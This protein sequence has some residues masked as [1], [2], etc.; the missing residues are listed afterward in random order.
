[1]AKKPSGD[2]ARQRA[3]ALL[4]WRR[5]RDPLKWFVPSPT[6]EAFLRRDTSV[7]PM[8]LVT[9]VSRGGKSAIT[10]ADFSMLMRGIHPHIPA[11]PNLHVTVFAPTRN[12]VANVLGRKLFEDSELK[13]P[14]DAPPEARNQPM[15]PAWEI[16]E[17]HRPLVDGMRVPKRLVMKNGNIATF[18]WTGVENQDTKIAGFRLDAAYVDE[19]AGNERLFSE[20]MARLTDALSDP[21]RKGLG[22]FVWAYTNTRHNE[23]YESFKR[24]VEEGRKGHTIFTILPGENPAITSEARELVGGA[25]SAEQRAIRMEGGHDAGELV[26]VF[27]RQ[28]NDARHIMTEE[29]QIG[30]DDNIWASYDPGVLHPMGMLVAALNRENPMTL[31]IVKT[32][33]LRGG[34]VE[35]DC[36][37]LVNFLRGRRLAGFVYDSNFNNRDRGGGPT[38]LQRF[39]ELM[40]DRGVVPLV[41]YRRSKKMH[42]SGI[43]MVR[44]YM[45]PDRDNLAV[46]PLL[47]LSK[48]TPEN[49]NEILRHQIVNYHGREETRFAGHGGVVKKNDES[50]DC[51]R[52]L[53]MA[54]PLWRAEW[55]CG[56]AVDIPITSVAF[57]DKTGTIP[58]VRMSE[59]EVPLQ[60]FDPHAR[61]APLRWRD[62]RRYSPW[63]VVDVL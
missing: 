12:Q 43:A 26:Q 33:V 45:A 47:R 30:H 58:V 51:L 35:Q 19:E 32:W 20:I 23:A 28:W 27:A 13:L 10:M 41:G 17:L 8:A 31:H 54:R 52:Y 61:R 24:R 50:V 36:D 34:T 49:G 29:Y 14:E 18:S 46:P 11:H 53:C 22:Y 21:A 44:H 39:Q 42:T 62:E 5:R 55:A 57:L 56:K 60:R 59:P 63:R 1:M 7:N 15:I 3:Q 40:S 2:E 37:N 9:S 16:A 6:Q 4:E 38:A 25:M 48:P